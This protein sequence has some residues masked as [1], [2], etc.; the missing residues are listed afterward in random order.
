MGWGMLAN[1]TTT[2]LSYQAQTTGV[3]NIFTASLPERNQK[4]I[5]DAMQSFQEIAAVDDYKTWNLIF[6]S[7]AGIITIPYIYKDNPRLSFF[8]KAISQCDA[9]I[10]NH[11]KSALLTSA[12]K[13]PK[14]KSHINYQ[15]SE[16]FG[17]RPKTN[18]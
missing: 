1:P 13:Y 7:S 8:K 6:E 2:E 18:S 10:Q 15:Y 12:Q 17:K 11:V 3:T 16:I 5:C 4:L 9:N 14:G